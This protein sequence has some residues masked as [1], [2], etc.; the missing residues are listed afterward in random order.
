V[1]RLL[2]FSLSVFVFQQVPA[3]IGDAGTWLDLATPFVVVGVAAWALRN[4]PQRALVLA[5]VAAVLYVDGHGIHLAA[6]DI[7][8]YPI[9]HIEWHLGLFG[10]LGA[11]ALADTGR[12]R[13]ARAQLAAAA[14]L[15]WALFTNTV[16]GQDWF[17]TLAAGVAFSTWTITRPSRTRAAC[18][19]ATLFASALIGVWAAW[20]GGVPQF[21][22]VGWI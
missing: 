16:E 12:G 4:A 21:S 5:A 22:D 17:L 18:A 13:P 10:L 11:M 20:H 8:H 2:V 1:N 14:L 6:N 7:G 19:A 9:S 3:V 15:G